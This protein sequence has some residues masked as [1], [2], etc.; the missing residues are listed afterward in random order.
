MLQDM[1][2][3]LD[4]LYCNVYFMQCQT[5]W[6]DVSRFPPHVCMFLGPPPP[7]PLS[8]PRAGNF[9]CRKADMVGNACCHV[10]PLHNS[11]LSSQQ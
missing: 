5:W 6:H 1:S 11:H 2:Y 7:P 3:Q 4:E 9:A 10:L 8:S